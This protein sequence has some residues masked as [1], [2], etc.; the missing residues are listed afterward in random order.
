[1]N[2]ILFCLETVKR[3]QIFRSINLFFDI[4]EQVVDDDHSH[5]FPMR[6]EFWLKYFNDNEVTDACVILGSKARLL[7]WELTRN[8]GE[9]YQALKWAHLRN[10]FS[11]QSALLLKLGSVTVMEFSH[12]G[13]VRIWGGAHT[14]DD[15]NRN[16]PALHKSEYRADELRANCPDGQRFTHDHR[17]N[18][19]RRVASCLTRLMG[20]PTR[21]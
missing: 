17:G 19:K 10:G 5:Q 2:P 12:K 3:W 14:N 1:M 4:I 20:R 16:I 6:R 8:G 21:L 9:N 11:D 7:L 13:A 15:Y 18:W